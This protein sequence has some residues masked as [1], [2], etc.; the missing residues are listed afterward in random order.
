[1]NPTLQK[2]Y[3]DQKTAAVAAK[4][5]NK[6]DLVLRA[7]YL[8]ANAGKVVDT[9]S[10]RFKEVEALRPGFYDSREFIMGSS[11]H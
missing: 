9:V 5:P 11:K 7:E 1:M 4:D 2:S 8:H 10:M 3:N 6:L